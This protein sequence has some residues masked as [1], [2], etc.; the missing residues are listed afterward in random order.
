[1]RLV[2]ELLKVLKVL[3]V[4]AL[5]TGSIGAVLP[6]ALDDRRRFAYFVAGPGFAVTWIA[7]FFLAMIQQLQLISWWILTAM[8]LSLF[9]IQLV[10][11]SVGVEGRRNGTVAALIVLPLVGCVTAMVLRAHG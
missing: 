2:Y 11:F 9:S 8:L 5:F 7:G 4:A 1:M 6:R 10:L 3:G